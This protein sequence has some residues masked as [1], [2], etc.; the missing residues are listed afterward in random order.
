MQLDYF[1]GDQMTYAEFLAWLRPHCFGVTPPSTPH[2]VS[3]VVSSAAQI[4]NSGVQGVPST[5]VAGQFAGITTKFVQVI[6]AGG[7]FFHTDTNGS[8]KIA[9][10]VQGSI[11]AAQLGLIITLCV[12]SIECSADLTGLCKANYI[13]EALYVA[14]LTG[15]GTLAAYSA[16]NAPTPAPAPVATV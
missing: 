16:G 12:K 6:S 9:H 14:L 11:A 1:S 3:Q 13:L 8:E 4:L 2:A 15:T 10:A 5:G 7:S